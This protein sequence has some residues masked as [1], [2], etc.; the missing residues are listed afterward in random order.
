MDKNIYDLFV[1]KK[2]HKFRREL[3]VNL[4]E[5]FSAQSL[6]EKERMTRRFE[7][8]CREEK[9]I[10]VCYSEMPVQENPPVSK[11]F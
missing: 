8:L 4:A 11:G 9:Q 2:H 7:L 6:S 10:T 3:N 5:A 1:L